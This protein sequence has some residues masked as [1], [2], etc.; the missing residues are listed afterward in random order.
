MFKNRISI[1]Q[2]SQFTVQSVGTEKIYECLL[3]SPNYFSV[4]CIAEAIK[5]GPFKTK[6]FVC[7]TFDY[8]IGHLM[9]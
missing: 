3:E 2:F 8:H 5:S 7:L 6:K 1:I 9:V 4:D